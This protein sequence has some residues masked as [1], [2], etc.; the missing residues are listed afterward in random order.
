MDRSPSPMA[1]RRAWLL[2]ACVALVPLAGCAKLFAT[3]AYLLIGPNVKAACEDLEHRRVVVLCRPPAT[4]EYRYA[5][6]DRELAKQI[7]ALLTLNV[8]GVDV[9]DY[10]D[11]ENW[12]DQK[13][14]TDDD[15]AELAAEVKADMVLKISLE[16][17]NLLNGQT[18]RQGQSDVTVNL[19]DMQ[20]NGRLAWANSPE[21]FVFPANSG[22]PI[23]EKSEL[24][25]RRQYINMLA[26][27]IAQNFYDHDPYGEV[28]ADGLAHR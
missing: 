23:Q 22:V 24:A 3:G 5:G 17:F 10:R 7:G 9:V 16:S 12:V 28:A 20:N 26:A 14:F 15:M 13:D 19:Y 27:R 18:L 21:E 1:V 6:A 8:K 25:F 11:V 4:L 2:L